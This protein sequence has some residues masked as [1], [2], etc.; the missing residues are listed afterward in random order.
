MS[1]LKSSGKLSELWSVVASPDWLNW[2]DAGNVHSTIELDGVNELAAIEKSK[3]THQSYNDYAV[4][5]RSINGMRNINRSP[6]ER[7]SGQQNTTIV[8][9]K[10]KHPCK[11][12]YYDHDL[13]DKMAEL[14]ACCVRH[15]HNK[16][17]LQQLPIHICVC[18]GRHRMCIVC[19][20]CARMFAHTS[21]FVT[22]V[23]VIHVENPNSSIARGAQKEMRI[24]SNS[25]VN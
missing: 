2:C 17:N 1:S 22:R 19:T 9:I 7:T 3:W 14:E 5:N 24:N 25:T 13:V 8:I 12:K 10:Q 18:C 16:I 4:G 20:Q 23:C 11:H 15:L 6:N 21:W